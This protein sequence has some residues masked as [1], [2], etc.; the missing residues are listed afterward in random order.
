MKHSTM[1]IHEVIFNELQQ[2]IITPR[3]RCDW[4]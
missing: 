1:D 2:Q 3:S 4:G